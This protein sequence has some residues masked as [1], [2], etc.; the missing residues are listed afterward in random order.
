MHLIEMGKEEGAIR[1]LCSICATVFYGKEAGN[2]LRELD[3]KRY[4]T[5]SRTS[6]SKRKSR[7][8]GGAKQRR[9]R[10]K[11]KG[12]QSNANDG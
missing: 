8:R 3:K 11:K 9:K 2:G 5:P 7:D 1:V 4:S 12:G 6:G 10:F